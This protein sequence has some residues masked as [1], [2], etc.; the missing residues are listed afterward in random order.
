MSKEL[1]LLDQ[2]LKLLQQQKNNLLRKQARA[3]TDSETKYWQFRID[4]FNERI[5]LFNY[6]KASLYHLKA[7]DNANPNEDTRS[8]AILQKFYQEGITL[9]SVRALKQERDNLE[10]ENKR[11]IKES[12]RDAKIAEHQHNILKI[13]KEKEVNMQVF[14]QCEDVEVYNKVYQKQE[15]RQ[16]T[17][18]EFNS[19]RGI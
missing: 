3:K 5:N 17:E 9:D 18:E 7:I 2:E 15:D 13:I 16:L 6:I 19:I 11:L 8:E 4:K 10:Y 12:V 14:N 1:E